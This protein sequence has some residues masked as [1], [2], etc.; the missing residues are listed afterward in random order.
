M[1]RTII[2]DQR[3]LVRLAIAGIDAQLRELAEKRS[4]LLRL[5]G[6]GRRASTPKAA[7]AVGGSGR[8]KR[9]FSAAT[10]KRLS[11]AAKL[12]WARARAEKKAKT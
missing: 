6:P 7:P 1:P 8:K 4:A 2:N 12:R 5:I 10:K 3:E 11:I 9:V